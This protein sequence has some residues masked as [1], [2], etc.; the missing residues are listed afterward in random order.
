MAAE[1]LTRASEEVGAYIASQMPDREVRH[2]ERVGIEHVAGRRHEI[3][4][5]HLDNGERWWAVTNPTNCYPQTDFKSRSVVLT[6]HIGLMAQ[7]MTRYEAPVSEGAKAGFAPVWRRWEQAAEAL[8]SA[9]EAEHFQ[10]VGTHLREC[11]ISLAHEIQ[12]DDL[13]PEGTERPKGSNVVAWLELFADAIAPGH[14]DARLRRYLKDLVQPTWE[15]QQHLVHNKRAV[16]WDAEIG[17]DAVGHLVGVFTAALI[18]KSFQQASRCS[19]CEAYAVIAG[20][21][22]YCGWEDPSYQAPELRRRSEAETAAALA[23]PCVPSS[24]ISTFLS[25]DDVLAAPDA[26]RRGKPPDAIDKTA[27][28]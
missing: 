3:W 7:V 26:A 15:Y 19:N 1:G 17:L 22:R 8:G 2:L 4:D 10:A 21:C 11:L 14:G 13:L 12:D 9:E 20:V 6:F 27:S 5:V 23:T 24:D 18:R 16:R 25:P 28:S